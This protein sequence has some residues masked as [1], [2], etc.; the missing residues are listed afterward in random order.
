MI[1]LGP[2]DN[3]ALDQ[4]RVAIELAADVDPG[5]GVQ[6][7]SLGPSLFNTF[8][9]DTGASSVLA[10][11]TAIADLEQSRLG[12]DTQGL[13]LEGGVA[14]D[15]LLDV[16]IPYR[17]D[18]AGSNGIRHTLLDAP[19][20]SDA[21]KDFSSFG[22]WGLVGMPAMEGRV[23]SLDFTGWS[24]GGTEL[25]KLYMN[26][27]FRDDVPASNGHRYTLSVDN[28]LSFDPLDQMVS[29]QPPIWGDVPF[30]TGTPEHN[31][32]AQE[33]NFLFDTG[34]QISVISKQLALG[35]GLD[36]NGDGELDQNDTNFVTNQVVGG[37]GGQISVP[38]FGFD[39]FHVTTDS[40]EDLVWTDLEWLVL[41]ITIPG[42]ETSLDGVFGSDL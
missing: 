16:S 11:A 18:F 7:E 25:D 5:P 14:G 10:M 26:T 32:I 23:T 42:E 3:I 9:L 12:Y 34:A 1:E 37:V 19:I 21:T 20:M 27:E 15:H 28:R 41:D 35:I 33:G 40:G 39:E 17:F 22:P 2:S 38:V 31:G 30:F 6:W 24:G 4:P 13:L 8:L 29:G 36:S